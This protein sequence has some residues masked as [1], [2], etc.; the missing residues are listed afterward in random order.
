LPE[1]I[2]LSRTEPGCLRFSFT[3]SS[4]P[5][6]WQLDETFTNRAAFEAHH[7]PTRT[8]DRFRAAAQVARDIPSAG[9]P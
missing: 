7:L 3:R 9:L 4:D 5:L 2:R 1:H 6:V 8:Y